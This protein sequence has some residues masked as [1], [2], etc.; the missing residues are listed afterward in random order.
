MTSVQVALRD[1]DY[2]T[3]LR[4]A[5]AEDGRRQVLLTEHPDLNLPGVV[6]LDANFFDSGTSL[7]REAERI[8][9]L[10]RNDPKQLERIWNAG[11]QHVVFEGDAT[12]TARLAVLA[13]E[14]RLSART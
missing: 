12:S 11:I 8:V 4:D 6:V 14:L 1:Q 13:A 9:V 7:G 3:H 5:L 2:A 10:A